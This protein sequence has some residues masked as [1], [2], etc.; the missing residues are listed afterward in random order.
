MNRP[1]KTFAINLE[2]RTER[3]QH[4][5]EQFKAKQGFDLQ[6][7]K[8]I[9]NEIGAIG[10]W[11]TI[12]EVVS[13]A[14]TAGD[15]Y[16]LICEDDHQFTESFDY[17]QLVQS[18][19]DAQLVGADLLLGGL[20]HFEDAIPLSNGMFWIGSFTGFQFVIVF[21]KFYPLICAL[22]LMAH[23]NI[24]I[25]MKE[26]STNIFCMYPFISVQKEFGYSDVTER[27]DKKGVVRQY[28]E[29]ADKRMSLLLQLR[30]HFNKQLRSIGA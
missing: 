4:I 13:R 2:E 11:K 1:I 7:V 22:D 27:N 23:E 21:E 15:P 9:K 29:D 20:S 12:H 25:K 30:A 19:M 8:A 18:I 26:I 5:L 28:F 24:D 10:L 3:K 16:V 6:I 14:Q 17:A